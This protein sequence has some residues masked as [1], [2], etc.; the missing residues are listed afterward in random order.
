LRYRT[1]RRLNMTGFCLGIDVGGT[2]AR[3]CL[4]DAA[5]EPVT[6][7]TAPGA[8]GHL[9]N[10]AEREKFVRMLAAIGDALTLPVA[11]VHMGVTGL[12]ARVAPEVRALA[13]ARFGIGADAVSASDDMELA[14]RAAFRP[15]E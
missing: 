5:G 10:S 9:F 15:G 12:G 4:A 1:R 2:A 14:Y 13:A 6:R 7:G 8:T 11:A 3:W